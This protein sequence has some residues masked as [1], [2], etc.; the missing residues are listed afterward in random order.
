MGSPYKWPKINGFYWGY[1][2]P[3]EVELFHPTFL[4]GFP[5]LPRWL[6]RFR[7]FFRFFWGVFPYAPPNGTR[8]FFQPSFG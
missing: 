4:S 5:G 7:C 8:S 3:K 1:F 6:K 2:T